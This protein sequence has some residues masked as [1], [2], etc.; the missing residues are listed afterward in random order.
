[1]IRSSEYRLALN[2]QIPPYP[3]TVVEEIDRPAGVVPHYQPGANPYLDEF[4][5]KYNLPR[6][7][8]MGGAA[9]MYPELAKKL[10]KEANAKK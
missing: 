8:T 7:V 5:Q 3:C 4:G 1:M 6:E 10:V 2:Q 9:T